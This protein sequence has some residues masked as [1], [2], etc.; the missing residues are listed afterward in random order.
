MPQGTSP[1][2]PPAG[3]FP[4]ATPDPTAGL[5]DAVRQ[6]AQSQKALRDALRV[7]PPAAQAP[8][9]APAAPAGY[10]DVRRVVADVLREREASGQRTAARD[11]YVRERMGDLPDA[12]RR[13]MPD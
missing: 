12:Y 9:A 13:L 6:L 1:S 10:D 11:R 8:G 2:D 7:S 3:T 4:S 5:T